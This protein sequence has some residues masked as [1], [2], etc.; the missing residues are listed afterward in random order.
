MI[1]KMKKEKPEEEPEEFEAEEDEYY[2]PAPPIP[3][4]EPT[5]LVVGEIRL[6]AYVPIDYLCQLC[7]W[8]LGQ[9]KIQNY[10]TF[11]KK[12]KLLGGNGY[13]G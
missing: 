13:L 8:L 3:P 12:R 11:S 4:L 5:E 9:R 10:L 6:K 7:V 1:W 2:S